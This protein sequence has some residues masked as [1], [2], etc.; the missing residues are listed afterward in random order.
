VKRKMRTL[1]SLLLFAAVG[2]VICSCNSNTPL[3]SPADTDI[4]PPN[5]LPTAT[6]TIT[7]VPEP[8]QTPTSTW[9]SLPKGLYLFFQYYDTQGLYALSISDR[10]ITKVLD[11]HATSAVKMPD[12]QHIILLNEPEIK[13]LDLRDGTE[14]IPQLPTEFTV[15]YFVAF[16]P[17]NEDTIWAA[18]YPNHNLPIN[19]D[20]SFL[21]Y[22]RSDGSFE[23]RVQGSRPV[24]SPDGN[25]VAYE[26]ET[27]TSPPGSMTV[28][29]IDITLLAIPCE[30]SN[31]EPCRTIKLTNSS[32]K[33]E[34]RKPS[35]SP[36]SQTL[37]YECSTTN[38]DETSNE[39][40][41]ILKVAQ[42]ICIISL[43]GDGFRQV[44]KTADFFE[45][46]PLWSPVGNYL[47]FAGATSEYES[48]DLY[49]WD[50]IS[51]EISNLTNTSDLSEL[52]L[53]WWDNR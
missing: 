42:D 52:P 18:G 23:F 15:P 19:G 12:N 31:N 48:N 21:H 37:A 6:A 24:W 2:V 4:A 49:L 28:A 11:Q 14:I 7:S 44:T 5:V 45:S 33:K 25:Y 30:A 16:S 39:P 36:D 13:V 51:E 34:A 27:Y 20:G 43:N 3:V 10:Q 17:I 9:H 47:V 8:T 26:Q 50:A 40:Q 46:Y 29:Y 41:D 38:Y 35:W 22:Y 1:K 53:F 32:L